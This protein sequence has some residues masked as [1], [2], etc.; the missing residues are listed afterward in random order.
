MVCLQ[1]GALLWRD[2]VL[3]LFHLLLYAILIF[4][5]LRISLFVVSV[6]TGSSCSLK[7]YASAASISSETVGRNLLENSVQSNLQGKDLLNGEVS[8]FTDNSNNLV[9]S[10]TICWGS[11]FY[12]DAGSKFEM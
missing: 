5:S 1:I 11:S 12:P 7:A 2:V 10:V 3:W 4:V 8:P 9:D 6:S